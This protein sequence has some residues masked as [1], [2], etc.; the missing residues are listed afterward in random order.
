M[1]GARLLALLPNGADYAA[2]VP[3]MPWLTVIGALTT[4]QV[5]YTNAEV[6][7]G[8]YGFLLWLVPLHVVYPAALAAAVRTGLVGDLATLVCWFAAASVARFAFSAVG[9]VRA[10]TARGVARSGAEMV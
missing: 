8:R 1:A 7:A 4:C 10:G 5:F 6:S 9:L 3:Y 2:Y